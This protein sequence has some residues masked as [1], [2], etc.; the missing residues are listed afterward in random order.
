LSSQHKAELESLAPEAAQSRLC[1]LN[2]I[3]QVRS[4]CRTGAIKDAWRRGQ[5]VDVHGWV[6]GLEDG[7]IRDLGI[8][9]TRSED[10]EQID[11]V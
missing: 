10:L 7:L 6:Y 9:I 1:E 11:H 5:Q 2:V 4:L 3:D 8:R